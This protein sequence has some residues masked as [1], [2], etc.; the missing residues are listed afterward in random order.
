MSPSSVSVGRLL[1]AACRAILSLEKHEMPLEHLSEA[2][3]GDTPPLI[4]V[5]CRNVG[6]VSFAPSND[7]Q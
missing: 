7:P 5:S 2:R 1:T 3:L 4:F 6:L